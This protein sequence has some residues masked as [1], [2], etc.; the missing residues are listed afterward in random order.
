MGI[1]F[2]NATYPSGILKLV[3][4]VISD[5]SNS[6]E[7]LNMML[8]ASSADTLLT[9]SEDFLEILRRISAPQDRDMKK[10][11]SLV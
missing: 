3:G 8:T 10:K 5:Q 7:S 1:I 6:T 9:R 2:H 11:S 4:V